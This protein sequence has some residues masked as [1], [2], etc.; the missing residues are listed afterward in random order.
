MAHLPQGW[1]LTLAPWD[2]AREGARAVRYAVFCVEQGIPKELEWDDWDARSRHC[3]V[4]DSS[5]AVVG[6]GR[7]LPDGHIGRM[8]VLQVARGKGVGGIILESLVQSAREQGQS[9]VVLNAQKTA[10]AFYLR[11]GFEAVGEE[12][13][14]AGIVHVTMRRSLAA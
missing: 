14:E 11:H 13:I 1:S 5:A 7:L 4:R 10:C 3:L 6:T 9:E 8:A 2:E 12:F